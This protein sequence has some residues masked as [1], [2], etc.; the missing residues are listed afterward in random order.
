MNKYLPLPMIGNI[1]AKRTGYEFFT[2][3]D[4]SMQYFTFELDNETSDLCMIATPFGLYC[5]KRLPMVVTPV[6][7]I[8]QEI[9]DELFHLIQEC[10]VYIDNVGVFSDKLGEHMTSL[11]KIL[12]ILQEHA[13]TINPDKCEWAIQETDWLGYWLTPTGLKP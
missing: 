10:D 6:P 9:M 7:D 12:T 5:Y 4:I 13:F 3:L 2:K 11:D 1:L 8:L